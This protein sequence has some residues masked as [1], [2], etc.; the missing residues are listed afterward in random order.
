MATLVAA[1][2][3]GLGHTTRTVS[4]LSQVLHLEEK[5]LIFAA[6]VKQ[7]AIFKE[8]FPRAAYIEI[9]DSSPRLGKKL[10]SSL[11][12][13]AYLPR[14]F[15]QI[16]KDK[17]LVQ[18]LLKENSVGQ[19]IS[20]NRYGFRT[21]NTK[22]ILITHQLNVIVPRH[23]LIFSK[24][25][26]R[27]IKGYINQFDECLVPDTN[28]TE[29][30]A[31]LLSQ[32][33]EEITIPVKYIGPQSRLSIVETADAEVNIDLLILISG[34]ENQRTLFENKVKQQLR[35]LPKDFTYK[36][37]RGLPGDEPY[38]EPGFIN[39]AAAPVLKKYIQKSKKIICRSG[40]STIMDLTILGK[41]GCIV[42]TPGQSEQEYLAR[43]L[44]EKRWFLS[45]SQAKLD[46][47]K[48]ISDLDKFES[49]LPTFVKV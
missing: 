36:I 5:Q 17:K 39:H 13:L 1:L 47:K 48:I 35:M 33:S 23:F 25:V 28:N 7:K 38:S 19:I 26:N 9:P 31:G 32:T 42:P 15:S 11:Q 49:T 41:T 21:K 24:L 34:P 16:R 27:K 43:H 14:F 3:W 40:Y 10:F 6:T 45:C 8:H 22:S 18:K 2:D 20:D 30:L 44:T 29:N 37:M 46:L 4:V 12:Y